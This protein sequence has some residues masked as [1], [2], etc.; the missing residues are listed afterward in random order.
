MEECGGVMTDAFS[1]SSVGTRRGMIRG[2]E[3]G[4]T[5]YEYGGSIPVFWETMISSDVR[6]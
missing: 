3:I 2:T 1:A 4:V 5:V 6:V